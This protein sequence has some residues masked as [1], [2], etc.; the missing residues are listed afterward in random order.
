[1]HNTSRNHGLHGLGSLHRLSTVA[2]TWVMPE[3]MGRTEE[4]CGSGDHGG[5]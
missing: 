4:I 1:M 3:S 2:V 5:W